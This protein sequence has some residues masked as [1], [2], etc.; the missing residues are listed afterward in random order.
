MMGLLRNSENLYFAALVSAFG[1]SGE[2]Q[3]DFCRKSLYAEALRL[4]GDEAG[5]QILF[6][7]APQLDQLGFFEG[8][9]KRTDKLQPPL[10]RGTIQAGGATAAAEVLSNLRFLAIALEQYQHGSISSRDAQNYLD[11]VIAENL[12]I[13][14]PAE[15]EE[16]RIEAKQRPHNTITLLRFIINRYSSS[17]VL[18][19]I[20]G[21]IQTL[22]VQRPIV[23]DTIE[24]LIVTGKHSR[25]LEE[26]NPDFERFE[27]ALLYP[28]NIARQHADNWHGNFS[29]MAEELL[30]REAER[31]C[32]LMNET[33]LVSEYHAS[34]L[35]YCNANKPAWI[36]KVLGINALGLKQLESHLPLMMEL[37]EWSITRKTKQSLYGLARLL[38]R[39]IFT[40]RFTEAI[41]RIMLSKPCAEAERRLSALSRFQDQLPSRTLIVSGMVQVLGLPLGIGQGNNPTCQS[42]RALSYWSQINPEYLLDLY[43]SAIVNDSIAIPYENSMIQSDTLIKN[44]MDESIRMDP[45]SLVLLPHLD[46]VYA[47][48]IKRTGFRGEDIHKWIN[49]AFYG[50]KVMRGF[51]DIYHDTKFR[52]KFKK[53]YNPLE[54]TYITELPQPAGIL[55]Y[56][57]SGQPL[58]AH[59]VLIQRVAK[60]HAGQIRVYFYNPNNDSAQQWGEDIC[61]SV[62]GNGELPGESSLLFSEFLYCVYAFHY[63]DGQND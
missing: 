37:I 18:D 16:T 14:Y 10:V 4:I 39:D 21:K 49:P 34:L 54:P 17:N 9:W 26:T 24:D 6:Q 19:H 15:T 60:D 43:H 56:S 63:P 42:T 29:L 61:T 44:D 53:Y 41:K 12:D 20:N 51:T 45:V 47:E 13:L 55:I 48:M 52:D 58:G 59:A 33:G 7:H 23:T 5:L 40:D 1:Q 27:Q 38:E 11:Q 31:C 8:P 25:M 2:F 50:P 36:G 46:A 3:K 28:T 30:C 35:R 57:T 32:E 22:A 62:A